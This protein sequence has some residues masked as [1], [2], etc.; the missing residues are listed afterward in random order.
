VPACSGCTNNADCCPGTSCVVAAG[1]THGICS[2]CGGSGGDGGA[3]P[4]PPDGGGPNG[5]DAGGGPPYDGGN[6]P[7]DGGGGGTCSQY[8]QLCVTT[9]DCCN[10]LPCIN[11]R[12]Q[13]PTF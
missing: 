3:P 12:C 1:S 6:P 11:F 13:F 4:P 5:G 9:A 2:P 8:G 10:S 7:W